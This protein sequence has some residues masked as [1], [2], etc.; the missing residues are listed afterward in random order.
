D[1]TVNALRLEG[2]PQRL[3]GSGHPPLVEVRGEVFM[4]TADFARLNDFQVELRGRAVAEARARW[5]SRQ[6]SG[7]RPFHEQREQLAATRRLPTFANPRNTPA[8]GLRQ[9]PEQQDGTER[10]AGGGAPGGAAAAGARAGRL[11]G[12][13]GGRA[14]RDVRA[15]GL[16][17]PADEPSPGGRG[18]GRRGGGLRRAPR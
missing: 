11:A 2:I 16:L 14:E 7:R 9:P 12:P 3:S 17:G 8:G 18:L 1:V 5:E 6:A 4:P 13:A 15:A 10:G